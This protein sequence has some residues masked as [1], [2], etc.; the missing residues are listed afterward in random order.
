MEEGRERDGELGGWN[1]SSR[2]IRI[3]EKETIR[4]RGDWGFD[5]V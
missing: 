1:G 2:E 5:V 3:I 4:V